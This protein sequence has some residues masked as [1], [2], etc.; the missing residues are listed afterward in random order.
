MKKL[1]SEL[2]FKDDKGV[3]LPML[4]ELIIKSRFE[5]TKSVCDVRDG[6]LI[7][8]YTQFITQP[9]KKEMFVPCLN[10]VPLS[11]PTRDVSGSEYDPELIY[12]N[13]LEEYQQ[14]M[15]SVLFEDD[16][17]IS[18]YND[19][20]YFSRGLGIRESYET[21]EQAINAGVKFYLK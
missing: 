12:Q 11:K 1:L 9:L 7:Y 5:L 8:D 13:E 17:I 19:R 20:V 16:P 15:E 4:S 6:W 2:G 10:G 3:Y 18:F 14:A 21:I